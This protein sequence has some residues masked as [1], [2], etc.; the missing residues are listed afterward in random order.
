MKSLKKMKLINWHYF[1]NQTIEFSPLVFLTGL[2]G[3]GKSTLIDAMQV[4]LLGDTSG[5]FFNKAATEKSARTLKGYLRCELGDAEDGG[6]RYLRPGRFTS[7]IAMEFYDDV[8]DT[9]FTFGIVF[10]SFPDGT[11]EHRFFCLDDKIPENEFVKDN[12]PMEYKTLN[13]YFQENYAGKYRFLDT[14]K[15]YQDLLKRRFGGL[16]D[17]YFSLFKKAVSF[18]PITDI[19]T[20]ITEYI[21]D[22][23]ANINI[24]SMQENILQYKKLQVEANTMAQRISRLNEINAAYQKEV[25]QRKNETLYSYIIERA[26][27][28]NDLARIRT[29]QEAISSAE[30]RLKEIEA[31][32]A[33]N[34][35]QTSQLTRKKEKL[36]ADKLSN[37][38]YKLTDELWEEKKKYE[39]QLKEIHDNE[40]TV[41]SNLMRYAT[42]Y[43]ECAESINQTLEN[44]DLSKVSEENM[45]D[46]STLMDISREVRDQCLLFKDKFLVD[47]STVSVEI[48]QNWRTLLENFRRHIS[49]LNVNLN[50]IITLNEQK[51]AILK[52]Q[53]SDM[54]NGGKS[55]VR[56]LTFVKNE[57]AGA[58]TRRH[59]KP[60]E[61]AIFAD[62]IDIRDEKWGKAIEGF[63][64]N[65]KFNL[66]V[67]PE[68]YLEAHEILKELCSRTSFYGTSLV[69][70][71]KIIEK[72]FACERGSLAEEIITDHVGARIYSNFLIGR[73]M[74]CQNVKEA[75]N[76]GNGITKECDLYRNF[77]LSVLRPETYNVSYIGRRIGAE[78]IKAK[79]QDVIDSQK[80]TETYCSLRN[81]ISVASDLEVINSY[82]VS[83]SI[84]FIEKTSQ[85]KAIEGNLAYINEELGK[86]DLTQIKS[87]DQRI[88][89]L[90]RDLQELASN[91]ENLILE[92]GNLQNQISTYKEDKL[93]AEEANAQGRKDRLENAYDGFFVDE[94]GNVEYQKL[95]DEG[96]STIDIIGETKISLSKVQYFANSLKNNVVK[97]RKDYVRDYRLTYD[98][99]G[100]DNHVYDNELTEMR[101]IKLPQYQAAIDDSYR[102]ATKEFKDDFINKLRTAIETVETQIDD[103]NIALESSQFGN[104]KYRFI[105]KPSVE[106]RRYYDMIKDDLL[107]EMGEDDSAFV[108]K[109]KEVMDDLFRQIV[110]VG[111]HGDRNAAVL[112]NVEKFTDYR[113]YLDFDIVVTDKD[114]V[115][116]RLSK[117]IKKKSGGETQT[118]FYIA[119]LASFAQLYR[120]NEPGDLGNSFR[121]IIFDEAFSKMD[122]GRIKESIRLLGKFGLQVI[123]SAPS[124][125]VADISELVDETLV[126]LHDKSSSS[127]RLYAEENKIKN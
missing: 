46:I 110:D 35:D 3:S 91:K 58:L 23:Q 59:G 97:L 65:Q 31:D 114:G 19:E 33:Y 79:H 10:D 111:D 125:K 63:L 118:P 49:Y 106:Y 108:N 26:E 86:H 36:T 30:K 93:P 4:L 95:V 70:Q 75:R 92:K 82:E 24:T 66:F 13:T 27:Y 56:G 22:S 90:E 32:L 40:D 39:D 122:R 109:Y 115:E 37:D 100:P 89:D 47:L 88:E 53:E 87:F 21:C 113:S 84:S 81:V 123:L 104:D 101:D 124:D 102:K 73:L 55:Y 28:E 117:T 60:V 121:L 69:D 98:V 41:R 45:D 14:N 112:A 126:V 2:N 99:D 52:Q 44:I 76:S 127:V 85:I 8:N 16:K 71:A 17:K 11:D 18:T 105:V 78:Q 54:Q 1:W 20:F 50:K 96:K 77:T 103:L 72:N 25:S 74:K 62:L 119:V 12:I 34:E 29:Y 94:I 15:Q 64:N 61:V 67:E 51:T 107:L 116:Q 120:V 5:R 38:T 9:S 7:Y 42:S 43:L 68:Y 83:S 80:L 6:F 48:L 57:L